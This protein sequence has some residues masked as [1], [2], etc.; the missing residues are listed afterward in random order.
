MRSAGEPY[1]IGPKLDD[2]RQ[3]MHNW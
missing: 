1:R 2:V 3:I